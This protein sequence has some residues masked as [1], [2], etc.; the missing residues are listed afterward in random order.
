MA[1]L[2]I[3]DTPRPFALALMCTI[4]G[5][6]SGSLRA[7]YL[8]GPDKTPP[9]L[10]LDERLLRRILVKFFTR[11]EDLR[12]YLADLHLIPE[13]PAV[14]VIDGVPTDFGELDESRSTLAL[15]TSLSRIF[16]PTTRIIVLS[17]WE[18]TSLSEVWQVHSRFFSDVYILKRIET[19]TQL[20][21]IENSEGNF[22]LKA[23]RDPVFSSALDKLQ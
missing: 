3:L 2:V 21:L 8:T 14:I 7:L 13:V 11:Q 6:S 23:V 9:H 19:M 16:P 20:Y 4:L 5:A 15:V 18:V 10:A 17:S 22:E 12:T 1:N